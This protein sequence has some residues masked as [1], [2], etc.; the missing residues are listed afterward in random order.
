M[1]K[2]LLSAYFRY[3]YVGGLVLM[4]I[5][6]PLSK[7]L[8]GLS[9]FIIAGAWLLEGNPIKKFKLFFQSKFALIFSSLFLLHLLGL[10]YT[11]DF[12]YALKDLRI[13][14]PLFLFPLFLSSGSPLKKEE[15]NLLI[16]LFC[17]AVVVSTFVSMAV[18]LVWLNYW[19]SQARDISILIS[20][21]RLALLICLAI[22]CLLYY[23]KNESANPAMKLTYVLGIIWLIVFL[24]ILESFTGIV[25]LLVLGFCYLIYLLF[26]KASKGLKFGLILVLLLGSSG[27][28]NFIFKNYK[29]STSAEAIDF[30]KLDSLTPLGN[31]YLHL[32]KEKAIENGNYVFLYLCTQELDSVWN[33]RSQLPITGLDLK[34][35]PLRV[36]LLRF[37]TSK[38][39]RKDASGVSSLS[40][41]EIKSVEN[42]I[43][44]VDFQNLQSVS[45]RLRQIFWEISTY[46]Q[47][48]DPSGHSVSMRIEYAKM[49]WLIFLDQPIFG[50]GTGDVEKAFQEKYVEEDSPI[51]KQWRL[52]A[53]NQ[54]LTIAL[55]FGVLG[56]IW[57]LFTLFFPIWME[58]KSPNYFYVLF[59]C[60][61][62]L[63]MLNEDTLETQAGVTFFAFFNSLFWFQRLK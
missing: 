18:L 48:G 22:F 47:N 42:G 34:N 12:D 60:I 54:Y 26:Q 40:A 63:S 33:L 52:R 1:R 57:F 50:V 20:H 8:T 56:L 10:V 2:D 44:N 17:T 5:A 41:D 3:I 7:F 51:S 62:L 11:Q 53:H 21:I 6:L 46:T 45:A 27:I 4:G 37:L 19:I 29:L 16:K 59:L 14:L 36:T 23:L 15:F 9:L 61:A 35:Q 49:G 30:S 31:P 43:T 39:L 55:T 38:G 13:K 32:P 28:G 25:V 24:F 58:R